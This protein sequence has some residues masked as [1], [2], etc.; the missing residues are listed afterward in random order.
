MEQFLHMDKQVVVKL[1]QWKE[2]NMLFNIMGRLRI[3]LQLN[4]LIN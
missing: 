1:S 4:L 3:E 2:M